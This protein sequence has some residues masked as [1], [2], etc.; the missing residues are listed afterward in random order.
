MERFSRSDEARLTRA[1][2]KGV[3]YRDEGLGLTEALA[4]AAAEEALPPG[5]V[6]LMTRAYNI[7]RAGLQREGSTDPLE[8]AAPFELADA[9]KVAAAAF[10]EHV[11]TPGQVK[12]ARE[13]SAEYGRP[14]EAVLGRR[15]P[16]AARADAA[17]AELV[18]NAT[19]QQDASGVRPKPA[20][21]AG[22]P[23]DWRRRRAEHAVKE[24]RVGHANAYAAFTGALAGLEGALK[25]AHC[26]PPAAQDQGARFLYGAAGPALLE[27]ARL[28]AGLAQSVFAKAAE[29]KRTYLGDRHAVRA[30][31]EPYKSLGVCLA[32]AAALQE[33][34]AALQAAEAEWARLVKESRDEQARAWR[35]DNLGL[36]ALLDDDRAALRLGRQREGEAAKA[37][38]QKEAFFGVLGTAA[39]MTFGRELA[40]KLPASR[41]TES[42]QDKALRDLTDPG[43]ESELR[44]I[45][46]RAMLNDLLANDDV[47]AG[48]EPEEV[49]LH[50]N[51][52]SQVAPRLSMQQGVMRAFL[53]KKLQQGALDPYELDTLIR[54]ENGL[55]TRD[56]QPRGV[57][58]DRDLL[59]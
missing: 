48:Y 27:H 24:A 40:N 7:G 15:L 2:E 21:P 26:P 54:M 32:K 58:D 25:S 36:G 52:L 29:R 37:A 19:W 59:K 3:A 44:T 17:R 4:K 51:E 34:R 47:I 31:A 5:H 13:V 18:K 49:A 39:G 1:L 30:D 46:A 43:H 10:P 20:L 53:R 45:Q 55:K 33:A 6:P 11:P 38:A 9:A 16:G 41:P 14:P 8:R 56:A 12:L 42:L 22:E 28:V 50:F 23:P 35:Y 57:M